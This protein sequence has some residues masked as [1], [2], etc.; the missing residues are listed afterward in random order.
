MNGILGG[1][2]FALGGFDLNQSV[3][4]TNPDK[5]YVDSSHEV[6]FDAFTGPSDEC[7]EE[8]ERTMSEQNCEKDYYNKRVKK[9]SVPYFCDSNGNFIVSKQQ[10]KK[11]LTHASSFSD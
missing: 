5:T 7:I 6:K 11:G 8:K 3:D 4:S 2:G 1:A 9:L 10:L